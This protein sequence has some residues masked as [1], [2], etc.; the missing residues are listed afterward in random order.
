MNIDPGSAINIISEDIAIKVGARMQKLKFSTKIKDINGGSSECQNKCR[1]YITI[2]GDVVKETPY[3]KSRNIN[4]MDLCVGM[5]F[6][7]MKKCHIPVLLG[8]TSLKFLHGTPDLNTRR[9]RL[10]IPNITTIIETKHVDGSDVFTRMKQT[11]IRV[12]KPILNGVAKI[13]DHKL[14]TIAQ[15]ERDLHAKVW[16]AR[17]QYEAEETDPSEEPQYDDEKR[18]LTEMEAVREILQD[19]IDQ[20]KEQA[21]KCRQEADTL[22]AEITKISHWLKDTFPECCE[23]EDEIDQDAVRDIDKELDDP[24]D[25]ILQE[26]ISNATQEELEQLGQSEPSNTQIKDLLEK[27]IQNLADENAKRI[28]KKLNDQISHKAH[29]Q[30]AKLKQLLTSNIFSTN[31]T[32]PL[33]TITPPT[34]TLP[35]IPKK[36]KL[37]TASKKA[38]APGPK[39]DEPTTQEELERTKNEIEATRV[40][41][42]DLNKPIDET[43]DDISPLITEFSLKEDTTGMPTRF[44]PELWKYVQDTQKPLVQA[45]WDIYTE[46]RLTEILADLATIDICTARP[47]AHPYFLAQAYAN[48]SRYYHP[49]ETNPPTVPNFEARMDTTDEIPILMKKQII[50]TF[51][52]RIYLDVKCPDLIERKKIEDSESYWRTPP[53]LVEQVDNIK[54]FMEL[55]PENTRE[56]LADP[57]NRA[58]IA[59]FYRFTMD[60][61][62]INLKMH[63]DPFPMPSV[64]DAIEDFSGQLTSLHSIWQ[65]H[66]FAYHYVRSTDTRPHFRH[67]IDV[68]NGV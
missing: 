22:D 48:I 21:H 14:K 23:P 17:T 32:T 40:V 15:E 43:E 20:A 62:K 64:M 44:P 24:L 46:E 51:L 26:L 54:K 45:R 27:A 58:T 34:I 25:T 33:E 1:I 52:Q 68:Y 42:E 39:E 53:M 56:A 30:K 19:K 16:S 47:N 41:L 50:F 36:P 31:I 12:T 4:R 29:I 59:T 10:G 9:S 6:V 63:N 60:C 11:L 37:S 61:Q 66:S 5:D 18:E 28:R 57:A 3:D 7:V 55:H 67:T 49:D 35:T 8:S 2:R 38:K 13:L 65:T